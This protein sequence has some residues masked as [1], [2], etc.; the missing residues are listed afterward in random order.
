MLALM[1]QGEMFICKENSHVNAW[2]AGV[3][4]VR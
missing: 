2:V 4:I 1:E 3:T